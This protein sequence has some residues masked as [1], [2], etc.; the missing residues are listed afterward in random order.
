MIATPYQKLLF[1]REKL[2]LDEGE[3]EKLKPFREIFT[4]KKY[5]FRAQR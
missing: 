2:G 5:D 3:L 4:S 1:F